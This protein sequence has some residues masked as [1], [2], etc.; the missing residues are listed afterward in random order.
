MTLAIENGIE[1]RVSSNSIVSLGGKLPYYQELRTKILLDVLF[2]IYEQK[3]VGGR[4]KINQWLYSRT[5]PGLYLELNEHLH[6]AYADQRDGHGTQHWWRLFFDKHYQEQIEYATKTTA[7][8]IG[9]K[10]P[11]TNNNFVPGHN[12]YKEWGGMY[13]RSQAEV[14]IAEELDKKNVLFFA[15]VKGRLNY[16][17]LPASKASG[18][19][20]GRVEVDFLVFK[21]SKSMILEVDGQH[22]QE[23]SQTVRDYLRDR[24]LL[25]EGIP[26]ARFTA[27]ECLNQTADVITEFLKLL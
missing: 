7:L 21:N 25:R 27:Q 6:L 4:K 8:V 19:L 23:G 11:E 17:D 20:S 13:F 12:A 9:K 26:T 3:S 16:E 22:H 5:R 14:A 10:A 2:I 15:N 24:V 18:Y 1:H